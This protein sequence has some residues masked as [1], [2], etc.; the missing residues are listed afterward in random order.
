MEGNS[1]TNVHTL[2]TLNKRVERNPGMEFNPDLFGRI[3]INRSAAARYNLNVGDIQRV[4]Q[5]GAI[6]YLATMAQWAMIFGGRGHHTPQITN[7]KSQ[8]INHK[9]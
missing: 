7:H 2:E 3:R 9:S 4:I 1:G 5:A 6:S 8:I